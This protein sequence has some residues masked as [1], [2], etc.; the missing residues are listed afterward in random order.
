MAAS[1]ALVIGGGFG[2]L[3]RGAATVMRPTSP[4]VVVFWDGNLQAEG[5]L[6]KLLE[7]I[8]SGNAVGVNAAQGRAWE[9][10]ASFSFRSVD[11]RP[12]RKYELSGQTKR[13]AGYACR[14]ADG[15][16]SVQEHLEL[17]NKAPSTQFAPVGGDNDG[18]LDA[19]IRAAMDGDVLQLNEESR[20]IADH[21]A[22]GSK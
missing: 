7:T 17:P 22:A 10:T 4:D 3:V 18:A 13:F 2:W 15:Q 8:G 16:W 20:L 1:L 5:T 21:W 19:A 9:L 11:G 12:C 14:S 6:A